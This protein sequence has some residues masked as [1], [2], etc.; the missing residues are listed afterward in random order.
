MIIAVAMLFK[1]GR[2]LI[3]RAVIAMAITYLVCCNISPSKSA[4]QLVRHR[5]SK[6][7]DISWLQ[8]FQQLIWLVSNISDIIIFQFF[9]RNRPFGGLN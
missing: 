7:S 4:L 6:N 2:S 1:S 3:E 5:G 9:D 8:K